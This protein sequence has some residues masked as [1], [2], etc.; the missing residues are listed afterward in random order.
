MLLSKLNSVGAI[1]IS[2][3]E[4]VDVIR[5]IA[6]RES[7]AKGR[8]RFT[9]LLQP[10]HPRSP[11]PPPFSPLFFFL[12]SIALLARLCIPMHVV[13]YLPTFRLSLSC[14]LPPPH[15]SSPA[16][17][18]LPDVSSLVRAVAISLLVHLARFHSLYQCARYLKLF[19]LSSS[20]K[21]V[22]VKIENVHCYLPSLVEYISYNL[23]ISQTRLE[24]ENNTYKYSNI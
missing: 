14:L 23:I 21:C 13:Y 10:T 8:K 17:F 11:S 20:A 22:R 24:R 16:A 7:V 19:L 12:S 1:F 3:P 5:R 15:P 4:A 6:R 9:L 2:C 18:L